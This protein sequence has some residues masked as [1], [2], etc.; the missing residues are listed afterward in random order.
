MIIIIYLR[1]QPRI[2]VVLERISKDD[3]FLI[4]AGNPFDKVGA[5]TL[6]GQSSYDLS[7]DTGSCNSIWRDDLR[8][9]DGFLMDTSSNRCSGAISL[10]D[11]LIKL[12]IQSWN[13]Y[14]VVNVCFEEL[15]WYDH[16]FEYYM[17]NNNNLYEM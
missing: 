14:A 10:I 4:S 16:I 1:K 3:T 11:L 2:G 17:N 12:L 7:Q 6:N 8:F 9:R 13:G 15:G 5:A